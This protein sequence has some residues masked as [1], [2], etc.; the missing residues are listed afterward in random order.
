MRRIPSIILTVVLAGVTAAPASAGDPV[1]A[2]GSRVSVRVQ[3][4]P[5]WLGRVVAMDAETLTVL[6]EGASA[7]PVRLERTRVKELSVSRGRRRQTVVGLA[8]GFFL[9]GAWAMVR[10]R[11]TPTPLRLV[12]M[13]TDEW[14]FE[15]GDPWP[16]AADFLVPAALLAGATAVG[17]G[18]KA[19]S[20]RS[21]DPRRVRLSLAPNPAAGGLGAALRIT[22]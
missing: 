3:S 2:L 7:D 19:E 21:V 12:S 6:P 4:Q 10:D 14:R 11:P 20:W 16:T 1:L 8:G 22:F 13:S 15:G 18:V 17:A 9:V 5:R